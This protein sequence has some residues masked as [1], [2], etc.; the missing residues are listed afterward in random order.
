[1]NDTPA[2][3]TRSSDGCTVLPCGCA[4][5]DTKW[6]QLCEPHYLEWYDRHYGAGFREE[7]AR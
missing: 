5:T 4:H 6:V 1:M 2:E 3:R 7:V